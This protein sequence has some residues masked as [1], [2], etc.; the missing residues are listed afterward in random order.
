[1]KLAKIEIGLLI[2][3]NENFLKMVYKDLL[4]DLCVLC[5]KKFQVRINRMNLNFYR[6]PFS[7]KPP[8]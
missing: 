2:N 7:G 6:I 5:G 8:N 3:F 1:M 4:C